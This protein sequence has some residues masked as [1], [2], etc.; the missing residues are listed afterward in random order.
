MPMLY[1]AADNLTRRLPKLLSPKAH[2]I[3]DY[4]TVG[5][6]LLAGAIL[7]RKHKQAAEGAFLCAG[8]EIVLNLLTDYPG[9]IISAV[10]FPV[11]RKI[12]IGLAALTATMPELL[13]FRHGRKFF[14]VQSAAITAAANLTRFSPARNP[15]RIRRAGTS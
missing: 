12:D 4:A 7:W 13:R 6:F 14:L 1:A 10:S 9:G 2:A 15:S 5:S 8:A 11:H 3:A